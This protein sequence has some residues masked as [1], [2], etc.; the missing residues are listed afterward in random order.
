M[1]TAAVGGMIVGVHCLVIG[2]VVLM[3]GCGKTT[4]T[5][6][7]P[8]VEPVVTTM[9]PAEPVITPPIV[10]PP[11]SVIETPVPAEPEAALQKYVVKNGDSISRIAQKYGVTVKDIT[12][13][14]KI[15]N[16]NK[17]KVGH[18]LSLPAHA[19]L[20]AVK[21]RMPAKAV[22]APDG[23]KV[24]TV[25]KG[26][27]LSKIASRCGTTTK[28][29]REKNQLTSDRVNVGQ[30]LIVPAKEK[31]AAPAVVP[32]AAVPA[33]AAPAATDAGVTPA[34]VPVP[35][36]GAVAVPVA[37]PAPAEAAAPV[38]DSK[39]ITHDVSIGEDLDLVSSKYGIPVEKLMSVNNL[40][41]KQITPGMV[42]KIPQAN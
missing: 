23:M 6:T 14:N 20:R 29:L 36:S 9:P 34:V 12:Q 10:P 13:L 37:A 32:D 31:E 25:A 5:E 3:G 11:S 33:V 26:D 19:K 21:P 24:Y 38:A 2:S 18:E 8:V 15:T 41:S 28:A 7:A 1:R 16:V 27:C 4:S 35:D 42:L 30:K 22:M 17:I 40:T 39:F